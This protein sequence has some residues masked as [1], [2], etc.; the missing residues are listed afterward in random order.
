MK[1]R[2]Q[3]ALVSLMAL[4][5]PWALGQ[6]L[7]VFDQL[8]REGQTRALNAT[9]LAVAARL[10]A[11]TALLDEARL[12]QRAT[13]A[14]EHELYA[15]PLASAPVIDGRR[16]D[17]AA[18]GF[19]PRRF[20]HPAP[21]GPAL[22]NPVTLQLTAGVYHDELFLL[23]QVNDPERHYH[24]PGSDHLARGDHLIVANQQRGKGNRYYAIRANASER[25]QALYRD[26]HGDIRPEYRIRGRWR[27]TH[28]GYQVELLL[29]RTMA[30]PHFAVSAVNKNGT[31]TSA[32]GTAGP[33]AEQAGGP[34]TGVLPGTKGRLIT[35]SAA[36]SD[37]LTVF[38]RPGMRLQVTDRQGW[39]MAQ[40]GQLEP[41]SSPRNPAL[42]WLLDFAGKRQTLPPWQ[43]SHTGRRQQPPTSRAL[44]GN[45]ESRWYRTGSDDIASVAVPLYLGWPSAGAVESQ[46]AG[47]VV[48]EQRLQPWQGLGNTAI[49][50]LAWVSAI[51]G[52]L[53]I[54]TLIGYASWL[55][56]R[57]RTLSR[58]ATNAQGQ[59]LE[60]VLEHWPRYR[61]NDELGDLSGQYRELLTQVQGHTDYLKSLT[62]KLS[63]ELRT[64]LAIV[65]SSLDNLSE[66]L[67]DGQTPPT[68]YLERARLGS[69]R[70][71]AIITAMSEAD[72]V[73]ASIR[74]S[75]PET[76]NL[77]QLLQDMTGAYRSAYPHHR[78]QHH[79]A[80]A[81]PEAYTTDAVPELLV[82]LLDKLVDNATDFSPLD[83]PIELHLQM[84][85]YEPFSQG[86]RLSVINTG[87]S[88]PESLEGQLF[89]SL[90]S[91]R[92]ARP[93]PQKSSQ[94]Q[95]H[96]GLGLYIV[97]LI[98]RSHQGR[99]QAQ[100]TAQGVCF[101]VEF[102]AQSAAIRARRL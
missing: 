55:S 52:A 101:S 97:E 35:P 54:L 79:I 53:L 45:S 8:L 47:A 58:A 3:L 96:L 39:K 57:I 100:N 71:S 48:V 81:A 6:Y 32:L 82:Q 9:A 74:A 90:T 40:T 42:Q 72:R 50:R 1:L 88:L 44:A 31:T 91:A 29:P 61:L 14:A 92:S 62:G 7:Q 77:A 75:E 70:L 17:W 34:D 46:L 43:P 63:H 10:G 83:E 73:E 56:A 76:V 65:R 22:A 87:P 64:P 16:Q 20:S 66:S 102:P 80:R 26:A 28:T 33:W 49:G 27:E 98:A 86:Y 59:P 18:Y 21:H 19:T 4:V 15:H 13:L 38:A 36:L 2:R 11:D 51:S 89:N 5:L 68:V 30:E 94:S 85:H 41:V 23:A 93:G 60:Q 78:F 12:S 37:A 69:E 24:R 99:A 25:V 95:V 67:T 84:C